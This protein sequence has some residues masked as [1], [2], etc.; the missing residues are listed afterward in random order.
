MSNK[1]IIKIPLFAILLILGQIRENSLIWSSLIWSLHCSA[2]STII[3]VAVR[4]KDKT[5]SQ[6]S[7]GQCYDC[8]TK[9]GASDKEFCAQVRPN[10][11]RVMFTLVHGPCLTSKLK[12]N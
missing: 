12:R 9:L 11:K 2:T 8:T 6:T 10:R 3:K 7:Q 1:G 5:K 4:A